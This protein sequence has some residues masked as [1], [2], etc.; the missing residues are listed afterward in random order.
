M[1]AEIDFAD[2][3][4]VPEPLAWG[5]TPGQ[6]GTVLIG[7]V[8]A[9]LAIHSPAAPHRRRPAR[10]TRGRRGAHPGAGPAGGAAA[11]RLGRRGGAILDAT[12]ARSPGRGRRDWGTGTRALA[13][14]G[15]PR[16]CD[17]PRAAGVTA[18]GGR[19][20]AIGGRRE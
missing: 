19:P 4:D 9:Y 2:G 11:D 6:L 13:A 20:A 8:L 3:F 15:P 1:V 5:L 14:S 17:G 18:A 10:G 16:G 12:T 7:A